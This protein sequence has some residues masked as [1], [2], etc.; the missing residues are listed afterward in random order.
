VSSAKADQERAVTPGRRQRWLLV[1]EA[2]KARRFERR[3][4]QTFEGLVLVSAG[5]AAA[6][7]ADTAEERIVVAPNG[8]DVEHY[9]PTPL[10]AE[11]AVVMTGS[12]QYG[13]NVDGAVW[14]CDQV[15]PLVQAAVPEATLDLVGHAP[16]AEVRALAGRPGVSLHPDVPA[17]APW[18]ARARVCVVPLRIGTGTRLKALEAMAAGRPVVGSS[19][20]LE[21]LGLVDGRH[22]HVEDDP[23]AFADAV[24]RVLTDDAHAEALIVA[25]RALVE[26]RFGWRAIGDDLARDLLGSGG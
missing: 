12:F 6:L 22:A 24:V 9:V 14:F 2:A 4:V 17:M 15:L 18:L 26:E 7:G 21:G 13:P 19:V 1:R 3:L 5:D 10:G 8:V 11:P 20:G 16:R 23:R 25:G